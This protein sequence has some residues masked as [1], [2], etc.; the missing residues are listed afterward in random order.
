M[1]LLELDRMK[2]LRR[3]GN[4][5]ETI[6]IDRPLVAVCEEEKVTE[7]YDIILNLDIWMG[8]LKFDDQSSCTT[9]F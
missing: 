6:T 9:S 3:R 5:T 4:E 7:Q 2:I 8:G 1:P